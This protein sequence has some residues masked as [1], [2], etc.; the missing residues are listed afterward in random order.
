MPP[1]V[2]RGNLIALASEDALLLVDVS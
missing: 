1:F 2:S